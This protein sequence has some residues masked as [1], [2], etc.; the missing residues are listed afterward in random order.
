M[1]RKRIGKFG[2]KGWV[3]LRVE[4]WKPAQILVVLDLDRVEA[5]AGTCCD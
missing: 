3:G 1:G 2:W 5:W 4:R